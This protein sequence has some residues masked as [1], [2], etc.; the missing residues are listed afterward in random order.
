MYRKGRTD[1]DE[2]VVAL[3]AR[4]G[5]TVWER[6]NSAPM[7]EPPDSSWGGQG[8]NATP[9]IVGERLFSV[10][11][12]A[13]MQCFDRK[14]GKVIWQR[15]LGQ[16]FGATYT[17]RG[18]NDGHASS[19]IAYGNTI[20]VPLGRS[21]SSGTDEQDSL[22]ALDR[23]DGHVVWKN[24]NFE[25]GF[26]S[27]ILIEFGGKEHL[28]LHVR[29]E[30]LGVD[31]GD[32]ELLWRHPVPQGG[33]PMVT[34]LWI[35][36]DR[37]LVKEGG[38]GGTAHLIELTTVDGKTVPHERWATPHFKLFV[39]SPVQVGGFL[40]G[41]TEQFLVALDAATGERAWA[42]RGFPCASILYADGK[43][44]LLDEN[45]RL[46]LATAT[47]KGLTVHSQHQV[48]QKYSLTAPTLV[49]RTL[50]VRDQKRILALDLGSTTR[51]KQ[52]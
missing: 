28:V 13:L 16:E 18:T 40:Y 20:I 1:D 14:S 11:S 42:E 34:P 25:N 24:Q 43:L 49:G 26:S 38:Q 44:I 32:G 17:A 8:P 47:P 21:R 5:E 4:T 30:M 23:S 35:E 39:P 9:L 3:D 52:S 6:K 27:P 22:V 36:G 10:G 33:G 51:R 45:G 41:S 29:G 15:E 37:I 19:P 2:W 50:F 48:T 46:S 12:N 7:A 31:P